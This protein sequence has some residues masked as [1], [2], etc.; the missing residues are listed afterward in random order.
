MK[1][2]IDIK[3]IEW[4]YWF[5]TLVAM[6]AGVS[7]VIEG[8]Y[9]VILISLIQFIHFTVTQGFTAFPTPVHFVYGIFTVIAFFDPSH[10]FY[11]AL[12][13]GTIMVSLFDR[14][15]IARM[16]ILMPWNKHEKLS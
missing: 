15:I 9:I 13:I 16:L 10:I 1:L 12:L 5:V 2:K 7:G 11:W 6:I 8:F 4:W 14:C 3:S